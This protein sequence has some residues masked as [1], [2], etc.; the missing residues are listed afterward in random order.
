MFLVIRVRSDPG[1]GGGTGVIVRRAGKLFGDSDDEHDNS[2]EGNRLERD[3]SRRCLLTLLILSCPQE[4]CIF[5]LVSR[6]AFGLMEGCSSS[7][8]GE[9]PFQVIRAHRLCR[10]ARAD[11]GIPI[12]ACER[13][14]G[15][16]RVTIIGVI[17]G[18]GRGEKKVFVA[19]LV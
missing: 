3:S 2:V 5:R 18:C 15:V 13:P 16:I 1:E 11:A 8:S 19:V 14:G 4:G 7:P 12:G 17:K 10:P 9:S 6:N